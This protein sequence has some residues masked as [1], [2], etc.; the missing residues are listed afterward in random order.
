MLC[1]SPGSV[2]DGPYQR[3]VVFL[4]SIRGGIVSERIKF[5]NAKH[6]LDGLGILVRAV[7]A[8]RNE[9]GIRAVHMGAPIRHEAVAGV[10]RVA[11][12]AVADDG[13][14]RDGWR[15][16][17]GIDCFAEPAFRGQRVHAV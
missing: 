4:F 9:L 11:P 2:L 8:R 10:R 17:E 16:R 1:G 13:V 12:A 5:E 15:D 7:V 3:K 6:F 14:V